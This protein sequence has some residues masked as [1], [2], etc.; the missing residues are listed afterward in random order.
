MVD[1]PTVHEYGQGHIFDNVENGD[2]VVELVDKADFPTTKDGELLVGASV[3]ILAL[4]VDGTRCGPVHAADYMEQR[5]LSRSGRPHDGYE[6]ARFNCKRHV[7]QRAHRCVAFAV[8]LGEMFN[9][10]YAHARPLYG[11]GAPSRVVF[12]LPRDMTPTI[13]YGRAFCHMTDA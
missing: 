1:P 11:G 8:D 2:E 7:V 6:F 9:R 10:K 13:L 3:D 4:H 12:G 5:G